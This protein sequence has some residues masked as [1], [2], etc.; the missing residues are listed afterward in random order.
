M[1]ACP[2]SADVVAGPGLL[3]LLRFLNAPV[4]RNPR[5]PPRSRPGDK[6]WMSE[7]RRPSSMAGT[8]TLY[9]LVRAVPE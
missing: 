2:S 8:S 6:A 1:L 3:V 9:D 4:T 5:R 7:P